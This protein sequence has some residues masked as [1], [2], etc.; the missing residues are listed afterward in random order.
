MV[1]RVWTVLALLALLWAAPARAECVQVVDGASIEALLKKAEK[2][3]YLV[4]FDEAL[5]ALDQAEADLPCLG[6][7]ANKEMLTRLFLFRGVVAFNQANEVAANTAF[8]R[9][10]AI[11]IS[12]RWEERFGQKPKEVF[13][14]AKDAV[15]S[16]KRGRV[17]LP[18]PSAGV[19]LFLDG[20]D[21]GL[22]GGE[23]EISAGR[24]LLQAFSN[25]VLLA[26]VWIEV[27]G[28]GVV[29]PPLPP[30]AGRRPT[31]PPVVGPPP[32]ARVG[33]P[34]W[35]RP[36]GL[37]A[38]GLGGVA[39]VGGAASGVVYLQTRKQL[40][41]GEYYSNR[42]SEEKD[43]LLRK[44]RITALTADVALPAGVVLLG[45]GATFLVLSGR[46]SSNGAAFYPILSPD[47]LGAGLALR[48]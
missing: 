48:F 36:A 5:V 17:E 30:E 14:E 29:V 26:G 21:Q 28:G 41:S 25:G 7:V 33:A 12:L 2:S 18:I 38:T 22:E 13:L 6:E 47:T 24:H 16:A 43:A 1:G 10:L 45:A 44:N 35:M 39:L 46:E 4:R 42:D 27:P 19:T 3:I 34:A 20:D 8:Q 32:T 23:K 37:G 40:L 31:P 11:S 9:A 15:A